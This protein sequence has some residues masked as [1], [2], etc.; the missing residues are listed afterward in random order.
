M[1]IQK[2]MIHTINK[3]TSEQISENNIDGAKYEKLYIAAVYE[4]KHKKSKDVI[5]H[6]A[7]LR[8]TLQRKKIRNLMVENNNLQLSGNEGNN[9]DEEIDLI[10][11]KVGL[12]EYSCNEI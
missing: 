11:D 1:R 6:N 3:M 5:V 12:L 7:K 9:Q 2:I 10:I 8:R 4:N